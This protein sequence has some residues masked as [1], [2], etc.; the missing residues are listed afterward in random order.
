[1]PPLRQ[2]YIEYDL[3]L[4]EISHYS[5]IEKSI[6][7]GHPSTLHIWWARRPLAASRATI[8]AALVELPDQT[9]DRDKIDQ[10][11]KHILP[12]DVVKKGNDR[13]ILNAKEILKKEWRNPPKIL[14][15]FSGVGSTLIACSELNVEGYGI[16]LTEK[17]INLT[18][19]RFYSRGMPLKINGKKFISPKN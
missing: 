16:E 12:W 9:D 8:F 7:H 1:M 6:R 15:P 5:A 4:N 14:D 3:P 17:W 18:K 13:K 11:I 10:L 2:R 19:N